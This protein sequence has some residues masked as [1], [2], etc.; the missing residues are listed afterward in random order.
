[1]LDEG[2]GQLDAVGL[3]QIDVGR[4]VRGVRSPQ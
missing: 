3:R 1:V 4:H 2:M